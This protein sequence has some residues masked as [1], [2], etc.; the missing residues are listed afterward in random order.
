MRKRE[1]I[2]ITIKPDLLAEADRLALEMDRSRSYVL[3]LAFERFLQGKEAASE[4][5]NHSAE[6]REHQPA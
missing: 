3:S 6:V 4:I 2:S 5:Q 1:A